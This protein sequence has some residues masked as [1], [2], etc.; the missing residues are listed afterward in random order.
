MSLITNSIPFPFIN[1]F[2]N[3][4]SAPNNHCLGRTFMAFL[5]YDHHSPSWPFPHFGPLFFARCPWPSSVT[6]TVPPFWHYLMRPHCVVVKRFL[7]NDTSLFFP[8]PSIAKASPDSLGWGFPHLARPP[9]RPNFPNSLS[10]SFTTRRP[11]LPP[12]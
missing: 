10:G 8:F 11:P 1:Y 9:F 5:H 3:Q 2:M 4:I 6:A 7:T 12:I